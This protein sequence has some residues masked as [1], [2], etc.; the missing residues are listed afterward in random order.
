MRLLLL[1]CLGLMVGCS[2]STLQPPKYYVLNGTPTYVMPA[3]AEQS[4]ALI[5]IRSVVLSD[6]LKS[7]NIV[8]QVSD[9]EL[10]FSSN[11]LWAEPLQVGITK[12]LESDLPRVVEAEKSYQLD[13]QI[14]YFH[15]ID[16]DAVI[17]AGSYTLEESRSGRLSKQRFVLRESLDDS[18]YEYAV[19]K[20]SSVLRKLSVDI[21]SRAEE[22]SPH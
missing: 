1:I 21:A 15:I 13:L 22:I 19:S 6:Y 11:N 7:S 18:G 17:L 20:M 9:H 16:Q 4:H 8:L 3:E 10:F 14:D 2:S 5:N 12:V